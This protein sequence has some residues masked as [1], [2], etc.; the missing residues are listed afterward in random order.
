MIRAATLGDLDRL[1]ELEACCFTSDLIPRRSFRRFLTDR[2]AALFVACDRRSVRGY[3]LVLFRR[4]SATAH[5]YSIATDPRHRGRGIGRRLLQS[6]EREARRR[7]RRSIYSEVR[8]DNPAAQGMYRQRGF[9][10][11][12][13]KD[14]YYEDG[15]DALL[16]VKPLRTG[17][18]IAPRPADHPPLPPS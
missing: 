5:I 18:H 4:G 7:G 10:E 14:R 17:A 13:R 15:T 2:R 8:V 12:G 6:M 9:G 3:A 16:M 1:L 11:T